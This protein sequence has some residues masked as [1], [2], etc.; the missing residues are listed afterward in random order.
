MSDQWF[1]GRG[2][3]ITGPVSMPELAGLVAGGGVLPTD[4][5]WRDGVEEGV[6]AAQ[7]PELFPAAAPAQM[8]GTRAAPAKNARATGG[9]GVVIMGQD[10]KTVKFKGKCTTCGHED[11]S[12]KTI[13]IPR[14]M[15]RT[16]FF[17]SKCKKRRD[18]EIHGY[19]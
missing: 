18:G 4:T 2:S 3:D 5:V 13:P 16:G 12:W 7:V 17:C 14:G 19:H 15:A 11:S 8:A 10:G 6:P 1:Y 9:K